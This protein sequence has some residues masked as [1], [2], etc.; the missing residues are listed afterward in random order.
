MV[1]ENDSL[2]WD[3][4]TPEAKTSI[5]G[6]LSNLIRYLSLVLLL[7]VAFTSKF[8]CFAKSYNYF[9]SDKLARCTLQFF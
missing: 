7:P 2:S 8:I 3:D 1:F 6:N 4:E 5:P 9:L